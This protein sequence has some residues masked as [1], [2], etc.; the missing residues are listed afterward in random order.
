[1]TLVEDARDSGLGRGRARPDADIWAPRDWVPEPIE[2]FLEEVHNRRWTH[3]EV[4]AVF[5]GWLLLPRDHPRWSKE[6]D[7]VEQLARFAA[8]RFRGLVAPDEARDLVADTFVRVIDLLKR[9]RRMKSRF[10]PRRYPLELRHGDWGRRAFRNWLRQIHRSTITHMH[11]R[12]RRYLRLKHLAEEGARRIH[13]A[14]SQHRVT[15]VRV[16]STAEVPN[17]AATRASVETRPIEGFLGSRDQSKERCVW[18]WRVHDEFTHEEIA[19]RAASSALWDGK[20]C[21]GRAIRV[22]Y[23]RANRRLIATEASL[24]AL[25]RDDACAIRWLVGEENRLADVVCRA[26]VPEAVVLER[27]RRAFRALADARA[28]DGRPLLHDAVRARLEQ[29]LNPRARCA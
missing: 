26:R 28:S 9:R 10:D 29:A 6:W 15:E 5:S 21:N 12:V 19:A 24:R 17:N 11:G 25:D 14:N 13:V 2:L 8:S 7:I 23:H 3:A 27:L 18:D 1:M 16:A 20:G 4:D 22:C